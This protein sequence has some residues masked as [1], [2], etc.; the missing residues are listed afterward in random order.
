MTKFIPDMKGLQREIE[1]TVT[2]FAPPAVRRQQAPLVEQIKSFAEIKMK[3][4]D[5][6]EAECK[7]RLA[8]LQAMAQNRRNE[9]H[10][11]TDALIKQL[12]GWKDEIDELTARLER[13]KEEQQEQDDEP[14][15]PRGA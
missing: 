5:D 2:A 11:T 7:Q 12:T 15:M 1:G 8:S 9:I 13:P 4:I 6:L 14:E 10:A 3:A